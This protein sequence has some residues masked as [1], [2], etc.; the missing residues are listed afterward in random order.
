MKCMVC[1]KALSDYT[2]IGKKH[3]MKVAFCAEHLPDCAACDSCDMRCMS[4]DTRIEL[5]ASPDIR[6]KEQKHERNN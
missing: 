2:L 6:Q 1:G 3:D 4:C 5:K